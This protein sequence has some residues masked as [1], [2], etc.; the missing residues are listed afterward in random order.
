M[1]DEAAHSVAE[2]DP[3]LVAEE[4]LEVADPRETRMPLSS[5]ETSPILATSANS[6]PSSAAKASTQLQLGY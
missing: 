3:P 5:L 1:E 6:Q 4:V 2:E